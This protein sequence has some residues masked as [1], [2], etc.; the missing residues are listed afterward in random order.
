MCA[1]PAARPAQQTTPWGRGAAACA[2]SP[3]L[4]PMHVPPSYR[5]SAR[6][7]MHACMHACS[8]REPRGVLHGTCMAGS[9]AHMSSNPAGGACRCGFW[10]N[11][12]HK[13][14]AEPQPWVAPCSLHGV[15]RLV[16]DL[17]DRGMDLHAFQPED[18]FNIIRGRT[19]W[20]GTGSCLSVGWLPCLFSGHAACR[21]PPSM[22][23]L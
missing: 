12:R 3:H 17:M 2:Q 11:W 1:T 14:P 8:Q 23:S 5:Y 7:C 18:L 6:A 20:C 15:G 22:N 13:N 10:E 16:Q 4:F 9:A 19:L 21:A